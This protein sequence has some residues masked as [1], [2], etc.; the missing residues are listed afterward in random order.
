MITLLNIDCLEFLS[1]LPDKA[2]ELG[3]IDAPYGIGAP[4]MTMGSNPSRS[5]MD[6]YGS[7]PAES[8]VKRLKRNRLNSG[9]GHMK[10]SV[11]VNSDVNWDIVPDERYF[12]ELFRVTVNQI[13]WGGNYF[14]LGPTRC[15]ICWDK[16]Q[17]WDNFSKW[18][19]AWTSFD[20]PANLF[21]FSN[22]GGHNHEK[23][24]H[25]TQKPIA[26]YRWLLHN[27]AKPGDRILDTHLGSGS[28]AIAAH[29][30]GFDFTGTEIDKQYYDAAVKRFNEAIKQQTLF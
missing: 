10:N 16:K 12:E 21:S 20:R 5:R 7:G 19:M 15:I 4:D 26:L 25:P 1:G 18:E 28:S 8:T 13:I 30:M 27:Y 14:D 22:T 11:L 24:I 2:F 29:Q 3:V 6:G 23:K 9:G 17:P